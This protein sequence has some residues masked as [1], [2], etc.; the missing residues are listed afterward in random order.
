MSHQHQLPLVL[1]VTMMTTKESMIAVSSNH[2][3]NSEKVHVSAQVYMYIILI[4][5]HI[6]WTAPPWF[7][8]TL[9]SKPS[10]LLQENHHPYFHCHHFSH[11][12]QSIQYGWHEVRMSPF[13]QNMCWI[14]RKYCDIVSFK[15]CQWMSGWLY[16]IYEGYMSVDQYSVNVWHM[17]A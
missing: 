15:T 13:S 8:C 9:S 17:S 11:S 6:Q 12:E 4:T 1:S 7:K 10:S 3:L 14:W 5:V 16:Y 2:I